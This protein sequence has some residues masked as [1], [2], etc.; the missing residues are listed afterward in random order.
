MEMR[1][2]A[3]LSH[4][5]LTTLVRELSQGEGMTDEALKLSAARRGLDPNIA[6]ELRTAI[7]D[8]SE[9][10]IE[11]VHR[12]AIR[13]ALGIETAGQ[14]LTQRRLKYM[15]ETGLSQRTLVRH[16]IEGAEAIAEILPRLEHIR[17][18]DAA[19]VET[20]RELE[21]NELKRDIGEIKSMLN[22]LLHA[23]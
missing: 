17:E 6:A 18:Q 11:A 15:N 3:G 9:L 2:I 13:S 20:E 5:E 10:I 16:E 8:A 23:S 4:D 7:V 21:I 14:T 22:Q 19:K 12:R 1:E